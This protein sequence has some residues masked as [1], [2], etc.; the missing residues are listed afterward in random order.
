MHL[1]GLVVSKIRMLVAQ[2]PAAVAEGKENHLDPA[3]GRHRKHL[4]LL[5]LRRYITNKT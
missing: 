3:T 4:V 2:H 5:L 1:Y